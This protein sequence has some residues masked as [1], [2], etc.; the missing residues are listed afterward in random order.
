MTRMSAG[1][2]PATTGEVFSL[3]RDGRALTRSEVGRVTGLSRTAN[4]L[5]RRVYESHPSIMASP[6]AGAETS[7]AHSGSRASRPNSVM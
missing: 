6:T 5:Q 7:P 4:E 1:E 3:V 2:G